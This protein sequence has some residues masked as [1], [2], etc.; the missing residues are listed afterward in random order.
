ML[1]FSPLSSTTLGG[2]GTVREV[3]SA[4]ITG[5]QTTLTLDLDVTLSINSTISDQAVRKPETSV[6]SSIFGFLR[7]EGNNYSWTNAF[8]LGMRPKVPP[9][10]DDS[11]PTSQGPIWDESAVDY[12]AL[13]L[14]TKF[15]A[16]LNATD[17]IVSQSSW[18]PLVNGDYTYPSTYESSLGYDATAKPVT[19]SLNHLP[20]ETIVSNAA[21][22]STIDDPLLATLTFPADDPTL[23]NVIVGQVRTI[24]TYDPSNTDTYFGQSLINGQAGEI[25]WPNEN[26]H[27]LLQKKDA[28]KGF[29]VGILS[30]NNFTL[31]KDNEEFGA[32][33]TAYG[34][35]LQPQITA[36]QFP[37]GT[38]VSQEHT[39]LV[40]ASLGIIKVN[41]SK[42]I[43]GFEID[44]QDS[45]S[46][47]QAN[48]SLV[49]HI[50]G[51][52]PVLQE[53]GGYLLHQDGS[54]ILSV[55]YKTGFEATVS[56]PDPQWYL[57]SSRVQLVAEPNQPADSA[58]YPYLAGTLDSGTQQHDFTLTA[59]L[60]VL[61]SPIAVDLVMDERPGYDASVTYSVV[62]NL[63]DLSLSTANTIPIDSRL[64]TL[65]ANLDGVQANVTEI[66][67]PFASSLV[68]T[69]LDDIIVLATSNAVCTTLTAS[70]VR[71]NVTFAAN[72]NTAPSGVEV[73]S[74]VGDI[75]F[76]GDAN[77]FPEGLELIG[78][79]GIAGIPAWIILSPPDIAI[80][81][82]GEVGLGQV[83]KFPSFLITSEH[84]SPTATGF[85]F[86]FETVKHLYNVGRSQHAGLPINR[87]VDPTFT[88][89]RH[90]RPAKSKSNLAA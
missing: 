1:G 55:T 57:N 79:V 34:F 68:T 17:P 74:S 61:A 54:K 86:D 49:V 56:L 45:L 51:S 50:I 81:T 11:D 22:I 31:D 62:S 88:S 46:D 13:S 5:V 40:S 76:T 80:I 69:T 24:N 47:V 37:D 71:G 20:S 19:V 44:Q 66:I 25:Q 21:T 41:V 64:F 84:G 32:A 72:A 70:L 52:D 75:T 28:D 26:K 9:G 60:G 38:D 35:K 16:E 78:S 12:G 27:Y 36:P 85:K 53:D 2:A 83:V 42:V 6:Y 82:L 48:I 67:A 58:V 90:I 8:I 77:T 18:V 89:V 43:T 59:S 4:A 14:Q 3:V 39:L 23:F 87:V 30:T 33:F 29:E 63:G 65:G 15:A 7:V 10:L 73:T